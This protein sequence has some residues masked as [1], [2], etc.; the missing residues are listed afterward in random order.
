MVNVWLEKPAINGSEISLAGI[1]PSGYRGRGLVLKLDLTPI[2]VGAN[3]ADKNIISITNFS[4]LLND[5]TGRPAKVIIKGWSGTLAPAVLLA[6]TDNQLIPEP[7]SLAKIKDPN[8]PTNQSYLIFNTQDKNSGLD[9]YAVYESWWPVFNLLGRG[10]KVAWVKTV[11]PYQLQNQSWW[12]FIYVKAVNHQG[13]AR[14]AKLSP[15]LPL[16]NSYQSWLIFA[17][18]IAIIIF[19]GRAWRR[20]KF[21][22]EK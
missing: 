15:Q 3:L 4:A 7:F 22:V 16:A 18:I 21:Y 11:S 8:L 20:R 1:I 17:I 10:D 9:Y 2:T 13:G 6:K 19:V 12:N 14:L 5:G